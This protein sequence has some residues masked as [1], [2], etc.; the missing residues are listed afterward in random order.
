[1][2][3]IALFSLVAFFGCAALF[4]LH[5]QTHAA[6]YAFDVLS[7]FP[8][9]QAPGQYV[10]VDQKELQT[11]SEQGWEL[12]SVTPFLYRNEEHGPSDQSA[13]PVVTQSYPAYFFK[14]VR[15]SRY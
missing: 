6:P 9:E 4:M 13:R 15:L 3:R 8:K 7:V 5:A 12:V 2:R 11:L 1:M 10:Q 14:R